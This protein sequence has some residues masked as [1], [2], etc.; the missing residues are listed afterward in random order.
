MIPVETLETALPALA[1]ESRLVALAEPESVAAEQYRVLLQRLDRI[2]AK[3]PLRVLA[4]TSA[5][6]G[7][8]RTTTAA[9]LALTAAQEDRPTLLV[10]TDLRRPSLAALFGLAPRPGLAEV[11]LGTAE[12]GP[13]VARVG[14]LALLCA[15]LT[16]DAAVTVRSPRVPAMIE[17]LRA[18]Y[19]HVILDAPPALAFADGDRLAAAADGAVLV[20]RA[21][22]TPRAVVRLAVEAL[23][24]RLVGV[25]LNAVDTAAMP[26]GRWLYA[27]VAEPPAGS[28]R[29]AG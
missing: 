24:E 17:A 15:G 3:R 28:G 26:H 21:G 7:E 19:Q 23:G 25:L 27:D 1:P 12:L 11:L 6:R 2:A 13:V 16:H 14:P 20:V 8:G 10:E 9:N 22:S 5:A 18:A 4:V 29:Q